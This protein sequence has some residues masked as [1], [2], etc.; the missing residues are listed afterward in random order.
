MTDYLA[1]TPNTSMEQ[2]QNCSS[3]IV[4]STS[5]HREFRYG[6]LTTD[7]KSNKMLDVPGTVHARRL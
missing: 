4:M 6:H 3:N 7:Q 1:C 5:L 2:T